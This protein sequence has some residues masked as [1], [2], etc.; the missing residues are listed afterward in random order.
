MIRVGLE[1]SGA[2]AANDIPPLCLPCPLFPQVKLHVAYSGEWEVDAAALSP[3][4]DDHTRVSELLEK[5]LFLREGGFN[6]ECTCWLLA[7]GTAA[8]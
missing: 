8:P 5:A 7:Y 4:E 3:S 6:S 2:D 1:R